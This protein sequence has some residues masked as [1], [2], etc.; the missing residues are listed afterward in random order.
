MLGA[1]R[2]QPSLETLGDKGQYRVVTQKAEHLDVEING[3]TRKVALRPAPVALFG[4]EAG[5]GVST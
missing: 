2:T 4:D 1:C 3:V 5:I